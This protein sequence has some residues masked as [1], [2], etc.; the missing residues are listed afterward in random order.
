MDTQESNV[1]QQLDNNGKLLGG[2]TGKGFMP[3]QSGN[4]AGRPPGQSIKELVR[5][6]LDDNPEDLKLFVEHFIKNNRELAWQMLEG[7][8]K[9]D[10]KLDVK[11]SLDLISILNK[12]DE[13]N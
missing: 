12:A 10:D 9:G 5:K 11:G 6:H 8:P 3:G 7:K 2:I 1:N 4:P 13:E